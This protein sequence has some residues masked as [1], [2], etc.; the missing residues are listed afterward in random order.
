MDERELE[1][2]GIFGS[3]AKGTHR[4]NS[5]LDLLVKFKRSQGLFKLIGLERRLSEKLGIPVDLVT[6][7]SLNP[8]LRD[9]VLKSVVFLYGK[10]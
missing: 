2:A 8:R 6:E 4:S 7:R 3:R 1:F 9:E 10:R 5:D